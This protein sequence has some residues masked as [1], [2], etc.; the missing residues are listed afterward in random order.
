MSVDTDA[1]SRICGCLGCANPAYAVIDH[2]KHGERVV[3]EE[4]VRGYEVVRHV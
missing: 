4:D 3:C 2:P 1:A